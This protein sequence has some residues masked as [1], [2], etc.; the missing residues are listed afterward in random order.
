MAADIYALGM[1]TSTNNSE[2]ITGRQP[3]VEY[4]LNPLVSLAVLEGKN[5]ERPDE[6]SKNTKFGDER[7][8]I[9]LAC[10][11]TQPHARP[12]ASDVKDMVSRAMSSLE[13]TL[14]RFY[15]SQVHLLE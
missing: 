9:M 2:T 8:S 14:S 4:D 7:W 1:Y 11:D 5:P 15:P 13:N 12:T 6:V 10:W 3:F